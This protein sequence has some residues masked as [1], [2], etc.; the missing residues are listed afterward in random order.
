MKTKNEKAIRTMCYAKRTVC[1]F[2]FCVLLLLTAFGAKASF[3]CAAER[4]SLRVGYTS[5]ENFLARDGEGH[6]SGIA[7]E[8]LEGLASYIGAELEYLPGFQQQNE[9]RLQNGTI[10]MFIEPDHSFEWLMQ[11]KPFYTDPAVLL[12]NTAGFQRVMLGEGVG[13][14]CLN[15][16]AGAL[17]DRMRSGL[18]EM[19]KI[20][21]FYRLSLEKKYYQNQTLPLMLTE[22]ERAYLQQKKVLYAMASPGQPPYTWFD[23]NIHRGVVADIMRQIE[24]DLDIRIQVLPETDQGS[25]MEHLA[26]G[27]IDLVTDFF[28]DYNW[29]RAHN[30]DITFPYLSLSYVPVARRDRTLPDHPT[31]ACP[32]SHYYVRDYIEKHYL[33]GQLRYYNTIEDCLDAVERGKADLTMVKSITLQDYIYQNGFYNLYTSGNVLFSHQVSMAVSHQA[34]PLLVRI[35]NKEI[36][37][38]DQQKIKSIISREVYQSQNRETLRSL[39][40]RNPVGTVI[41]LSV[42]FATVL[43]VLLFWMRMRR[44]HN[45]ELYRQA[46]VIEDIGMYNLR[47]FRRE[48]PRALAQYQEDREAGR[49]FLMVL[50]AQHISFLKEIYHAGSFRESIMNL[51][52][53]VRAENDWLL[54]DAMT[55]DLFSLIVLCRRPDGMSMKQAAAKVAHDARICVFNGTPT[56]VRYHIGLCAIP[57]KGDIHTDT[58]VD[59]AFSAHNETMANRQPVGVY[60][61]AM[62]NSILRQKQMESLMEK[63][64]AKGEFK[65]YLQAKYNIDAQSVCAAESLVR[66][67][68]PELGFLMPGQFIGLFEHNGFIVQ[69]DYYMLEQV[70]QYQKNRLEHGQ[71]TVPISVNQ[72]GMHIKEENYLERMQAIADKYHLPSGLIDLELTETA[73]IDF[74]TQDARRD[75]SRIVTSLKKMGYRLSMDDFCTGYSS[76]AM[77]QN[78]PMD[79]MK[80]DRS[81]LLAAE[82]SPRALT[83][84][85]HV[86]ELGHSLDMR[87]LVEGIETRPQELLLLGIDCHYGQGFLFAKPMPADE[88]S[89]FLEHH[90]TE[91]HILP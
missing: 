62:Q 60:D 79:V 4:M 14:L 54:I 57:P 17:T 70:C 90:T 64:L 41:F 34:D 75:A 21:P 72:S 76:I 47:W 68:S 58:W 74:S 56:S 10:D 82:T 52:R 43:L 26:A 13:V 50:S 73:F 22:E 78:L 32:R 89:E 69:L 49:L 67:A 42:I 2:L 31:V 18:T 39:I 12:Q 88:F 38:L 53:K 86:V 3:A 83:I 59:N 61:Y 23:G 48:L 1:C 24:K 55:S 45:Q 5:M 15:E 27:D 36:A 65:V 19:T 66:W 80:I 7:Y 16:N 87:V 37:H 40:Y 25:M 8:Y 20:N 71:I 11:G 81:M 46:H 6:Y 35:L 29:A 77:L 33:P 9:E 51:I 84:L 85:R 63:A 30:V 91:G 28:T 44:R